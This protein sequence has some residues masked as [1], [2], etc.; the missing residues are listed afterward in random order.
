[1]V[2]GK[3]G[4]VGVFRKYWIRG[5]EVFVGGLKVWGFEIDEFM[6]NGLG[7]NLKLG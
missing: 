1:M 5:I 2:I 4:V 3:G 7:G 6:L